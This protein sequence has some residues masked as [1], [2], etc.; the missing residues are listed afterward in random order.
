MQDFQ[1]DFMTLKEMEIS[2]PNSKTPSSATINFGIWNL[3]TNKEIKFLSLTHT[4]TLMYYFQNNASVSTTNEY[5]DQ[6]GGQKRKDHKFLA[7][8]IHLPLSQFKFHI[9]LCLTSNGSIICP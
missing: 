5:K 8:Y 6:Y 4:I 2:E 3:T 9:S 7:K 1:P